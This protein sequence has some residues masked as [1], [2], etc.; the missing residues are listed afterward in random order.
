MIGLYH[1][2]P[3]LGHRQNPFTGGDNY[4]D[5][6]ANERANGAYRNETACEQANG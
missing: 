5:S 6:G 1:L 2:R 3:H 4:P